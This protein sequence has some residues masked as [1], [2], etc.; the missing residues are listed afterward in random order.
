MNEQS[1]MN[2][3][4]V[5]LWLAIVC[6]LIVAMVAVGGAT[7]LTGSGLSMV[8]WKPIMGAVPPLSEA[9]WDAAFSAYRESP[10]YR[11]V[12]QG[13]TPAEF[14]SIFLW[15]Y[16]HRLLARAVGLV[17]LVPLVVFMIQG[18]VRGALAWKLGLGFAVGGLQGLMG[19]YM[20]K[21][22][23]V[24]VPQVSHLR[25]AAHLS[26]ALVLFGYLFWIMCSLMR[27]KPREETPPQPLLRAAFIGFAVLLA[28]QIVYGAFMAGLRAGL[29][30]QTFPKM[31]GY[32]VPP[33]LLEL[34]PV[35][36]NFTD[37]TTLV[38]FIH[39]GLGWIIGFAALAL[40]ASAW[41][42]G[43]R[44]GQKRL[45]HGLVACVLLQF[46]LGVATL[47]LSLPLVPAVLH[48]VVAC[49]VLALTLSLIHSTG[50][51]PAMEALP[52]SARDP[53]SLSSDGMLAD[54][55]AARNVAE[56]GRSVP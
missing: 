50:R 30:F 10:Q 44:P 14:K 4:P 43:T 26:L 15:E 34:E 27:E 21:S 8:D 51:H 39:R 23:L 40:W 42:G 32:W 55:G 9:D 20:V 36:R 29:A 46:G 22:G 35:W 47:L 13:M 3:R 53:V 24:D 49:L 7:R 33:G 41:T 48:Q 12:N 11:L 56:L 6:I 25:L 37:N 28:V 16:S 52:V 17:Y 38:Q 5:I 31:L 18:R 2:L 19:W 1:S 54:L 45:L